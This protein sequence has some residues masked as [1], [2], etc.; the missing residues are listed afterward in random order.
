[1]GVAGRWLAI[2]ALM[3]VLIGPAYSNLP[4]NASYEQLSSLNQA[5]AEN[6]NPLLQNSVL[7]LVSPSRCPAGGCSPGQR[8]NFSYQ[9]TLGAY[10]P[11]PT[12]PPAPNVKICFYTPVDWAN[13]TSINIDPVGGL[14]DIPYQLSDN[15]A[16]APAAP[17]GYVLAA[18][19]QAVISQNIFGD[20]LG[21]AFRL[22]STASTHGT[23][24]ARLLERSTSGW[25]VTRDDFTPSIPVT[26]LPGSG[27]VNVYVANDP[28]DCESG[29][30]SPCYLN[31]GHD[32]VGGVGT[33]LKDAVDAVP[34]GSTLS[35]VS[36]YSVKNN[37]VVVNKRLSLVG[38]T[39]SKITYSGNTC[40]QPIL[41]L[42]AGVT[43]RD[44]EIND[45]SSCTGPNRTLI[46]INSSEPVVIE[47]NHLSGGDQAINIRDN[48]GDITV[49]YN[50]IEN[51]F[52][53]GIFWEIGQSTATLD[54]IANN[55]VNNGSPIE[56]G[57][58]Q[59]A[60]VD[61]RKADHNYWGSTTAPS[62][63]STHCN[64]TPGR[65][66]GAPVVQ[67]VGMP[68]LQVQRVT[69]T[70]N[71]TYAFDNQVAFRR[72]SADHDYGLYIINHGYAKESGI[73]FTL[74]EGTNPNPCSNYW[75]IFLAEGAA[76]TG[77]LDL[78]LKYGA[79]SPACI[80]VINSNQFCDQVS[81]KTKYPLW[82]YDPVFGITDWWDTTGQEPAGRNAGE[83]QGQDTQCNIAENE[84]QVAIDND[85]RP[86]L[87]DDLNSL[88]LMVGIEV[89]KTFRLLAS[90][91]NITVDWS[92]ANEPDI[93]GFYVL[94]SM[95]GVNFS[96]ITDL[97]ARKGSALAGSSYQHLD[98]NRVAGTIYYYRLKIIRSD[99][100][101]LYSVI[102]S[103]VA[104]SAT[105]TITPTF[106]PTRTFTRTPGPSPTFTVPPPTRTNTPTR[107][108]TRV[109]TRIPSITLTP[110]PPTA[111]QPVLVL[112]THTPTPDSLFPE[113]PGYP[114]PGLDTETATATP[115]PGTVIITPSETNIPTA[116]ATTASP[117]E[118]EQRGPANPLRLLQNILTGFA[119]G[120][121]TLG[122]ITLWYFYIRKT[123][124]A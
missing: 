99:G 39:G 105:A 83:S 31:S 17:D 59:T 111:T 35:I 120:M 108:P 68:G 107:V 85:G 19:S 90:N 7:S 46:D 88:S 102:Q 115:T 54:V 45:G 29:P 71:K 70:G 122:I 56:C 124:S 10:D 62:R 32:F 42:Q 11:T 61:Y 92:T 44:L 25:A 72:S 123:P 47:S 27:P 118:Q 15:C 103:V 81:D 55:I 113:T 2:F 96:P 3:L 74:A 93:S 5:V 14:T 101:A 98:S 87:A 63:E 75:N 28:I 91:N 53:F 104:T 22:S 50:Q 67:R 112:D 57:A 16:E 95:D 24:Y 66:L 38:L 84:I 41:S 36:Q 20:T 65:Q 12:T 6:A 78:F 48:T 100:N 4:A 26:G 97:I 109:P 94:R 73:P 40:S 37:A 9:F 23:L 121:V 110:R 64:I 58:G 89:L 117:T 51:N 49:R 8:L 76:P 33:G 21:I 114:V 34:A 82:W 116:S 79:N 119:C 86:N 52:G 43:L 30:F 1:M 80:A 18:A 106:G 69:V 60:P 77:T 13:L